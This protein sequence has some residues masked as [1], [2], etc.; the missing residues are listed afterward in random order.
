MFNPDVRLLRYINVGTGVRID[1]W[2]AAVGAFLFA[3][4]TDWGVL[5]RAAR[6]TLTL[7]S[8][9]STSGRLDQ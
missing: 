3:E 9:V 6:S 1:R 5:I 4:R 2:F 8:A 7:D